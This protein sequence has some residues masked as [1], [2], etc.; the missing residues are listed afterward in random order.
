MVI[1]SE[2]VGTYKCILVE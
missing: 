1:S 2:T